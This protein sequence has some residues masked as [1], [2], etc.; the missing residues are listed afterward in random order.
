[1]SNFS[2]PDHYQGVCLTFNNDK[3]MNYERIHVLIQTGEL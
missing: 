2:T 3:T 1:M